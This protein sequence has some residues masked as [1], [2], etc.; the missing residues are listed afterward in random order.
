VRVW[1]EVPLQ[2]KV[3]ILLLAQERAP[4]DGIFPP[5]EGL[6]ARGVIAL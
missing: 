5:R 1:A 2:G 4:D 6:R 3:A